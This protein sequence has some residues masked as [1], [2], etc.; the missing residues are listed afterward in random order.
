MRLIEA[1]SLLQKASVTEYSQFPVALICGFTPQPLRTFLAAHLQSRLPER[2]VEM[3][4]GRFGDLTGNLE[5]YLQEP[6]GTAAVVLEWPDLDSRLGWRQH[7]GWGRARTADICAVVERQ[8]NTLERLLS[9]AS[10]AGVIALALPSAPI[11][12]V[13]P[14]PRWQYGGLQSQLDAL[15]QMFAARRSSSRHLRLLNPA[16]LDSLSPVQQR[17]DV[18]TLNQ[19]GYPYQL[20][21]TDALAG[22]L[23]QLLLPP[24]LRKGIITDLDNTLWSGILGEIGVEGVAWDLDQ[25]SAQHGAY[26]QML[27][28]L[29]DSGV[30]V[31][32]ASKNDP[33]LVATALERPDILLRPASVFPVEAHWSPK[34]ESV[35]RILKAWNIGADSVIFI[36]DSPLELAEVKNAHPG[37]DCRQFFHEDPNQVAALLYEL[38]DLFGKPFDS[39]EDALRLQSLRASAVFE[40]GGGG[41]ES[42]D[43]VLAGAEG[44]LQ[45][46]TLQDPPDPRALELVNKTNQFNLNGKRFKDADWLHYLKSPDHL[47]WMASYSDRFGALGKIAVLAGH[48]IGPDELQVDAWVLSC[49]AFAR[50][51][52]YAMLDGLFTRHGIRKVRFCFEATERNGPTQELLD[53]LLG[54]GRPADQNTLVVTD[55]EQRKLLWHMRVEY[56]YG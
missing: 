45:I 8:L 53:A 37:I 33:K 4:E 6:C 27:Q 47:I 38:A 19:A 24:A 40:A 2:R 20:P 43:E 12:P 16:Y 44:V 28:S 21:H 17:V 39:E 51:I 46:L 54:A 56:P 11:A 15:L 25:H 32:I 23:A 34:S 42:L 41:S 10:G 31:A 49:R 5:R 30:L 9:G 13:E 36:D 55:F 3:R 22:A 14:L 18:K 1:L 35:A 50:R 7:G 48:K 26:Q 52:E 29:A